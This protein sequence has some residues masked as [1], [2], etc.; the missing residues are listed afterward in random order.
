MDPV[1]GIA[2]PPSGSHFLDEEL[3]Y[4]HTE[5]WLPA[6]DQFGDGLTHLV[7]EPVI[8][9][10]G[11]HAVQNVSSLLVEDGSFLQVV[12]KNKYESSP[13]QL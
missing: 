8:H 5:Q 10:A 3:R 2:T 13:I 1:F 4:L 7:A 6:I 12:F 9:V 11:Q